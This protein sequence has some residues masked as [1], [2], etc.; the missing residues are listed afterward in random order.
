MLKNT[1]FLL[2]YLCCCVNNDFDLNFSAKEE[3][4]G[5]GEGPS[6][7]EM[8]TN[9]RES[10][11]DL[12]GTTERVTVGI[13]RNAS[14]VAQDC[15]TPSPVPVCYEETSVVDSFLKSLGK[16]DLKL[17]SRGKDRFSSSPWSRN[18]AHM[19]R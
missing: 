5:T 17:L 9:A 15:L 4:I 19:S 13:E 14:Q 10:N 8:L 2:L 11:S 7:I 12:V 6:D 18:H 16:V 3:C 1:G